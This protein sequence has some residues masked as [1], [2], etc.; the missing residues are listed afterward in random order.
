MERL[1]TENFKYPINRIK[2]KELQPK[3]RLQFY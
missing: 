3:D 1:P 2:K